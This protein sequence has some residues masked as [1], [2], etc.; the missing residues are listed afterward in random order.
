MELYLLIGAGFCAGFVDAVAGGGGLISL[1]ALLALGLPPVTAL[2]TNKAI[3]ICT[4]LASSF[5][6]F[7]SGKVEWRKTLPLALIAGICSSVGSLTATLTRPE[8]LRPIIVVGLVIVGIYTVSHQ[9]FGLSKNR[10]KFPA[11]YFG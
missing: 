7:L 4:S 3:G 8:V 11:P 1:P 5:R 10:P 6:Y 9:A 2:G